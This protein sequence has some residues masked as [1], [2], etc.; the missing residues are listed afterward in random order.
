MLDYPPMCPYAPG[1]PSLNVLDDGRG[2]TT[3]KIDTD[4]AQ[5]RVLFSKEGI[6]YDGPDERTWIYHPSFPR[7]PKEGGWCMDDDDDNNNGDD[8]RESK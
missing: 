2:I 4:L 3:P 5:R 7:T 1:P 8:D 6:P